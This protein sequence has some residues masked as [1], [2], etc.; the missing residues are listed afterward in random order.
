MASKGPF[1]LPQPS[2]LY[3]N[4]VP[5]RQVFSGTNLDIDSW[6]PQYYETNG[7][8]LYT[9]GQT[10]K[11]R[12]VAISL[13]NLNNLPLAI[14]FSSFMIGINTGGGAGRTCNFTSYLSFFL[15]QQPLVNIPVSAMWTLNTPAAT[16]I[17]ATTNGLNSALQNLQSIDFA[18]GAGAIADFGIQ[19][20]TFT[21]P[22]VFNPYTPP[23]LPSQLFSF[24]FIWD[25]VTFTTTVTPDLTAPGN[26]LNS[27]LAGIVAFSMR[28]KNQ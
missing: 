14:A 6:A 23:M 12:S 26:I 18:A 8:D 15:K 5:G 7:I 16:I 13:A 24:P 20:P 3:P 10:V 9:T 17:K 19:L 25:Q 4:Q 28:T 11:I 27:L 1:S 21:D 22:A 2:P